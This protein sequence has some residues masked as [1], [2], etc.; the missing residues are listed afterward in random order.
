MCVCARMGVEWCVHSL[1]NSHTSTHTHFH[2]HTH[3]PTHTLP[4]SLTRIHSHTHTHSLAF[5]RLHNGSTLHLCSAGLHQPRL[6]APS[7]LFH[8]AT[9]SFLT[10]LFVHVSLFMSPPLSIFKNRKRC[11][12][13]YFSN[14]NSH[15]FCLF[16]LNLQLH[17]SKSARVPIHSHQTQKSEDE[18]RKEKKR[19]EK[20]RKE[21]KR[22]EKERNDRT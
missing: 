2:T 12:S 1:V 6:D 20:K 10:H 15:P 8:R 5:I 21:K 3:T 7:C 16:R 14:T 22:K 13:P 11:C 4:R 18:K 9:T 17:W 19:K